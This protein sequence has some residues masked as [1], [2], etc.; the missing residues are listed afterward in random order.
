MKID[1]MAASR[2]RARRVRRPAAR[3]A[4]SIV[5]VPAT[6]KQRRISNDA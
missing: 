1:F 6:A 3:Q 4:V 2:D 5:A